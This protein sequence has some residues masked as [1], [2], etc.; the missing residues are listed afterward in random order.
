MSLLHSGLQGLSRLEYFFEQKAKESESQMIPFAVLG[1]LI[2]FLFNFTLG[3]QNG[4]HFLPLIHPEVVVLC[5][6]LLL[7]NYWPSR[8]KPLLSWYWFLCIFYL[9]P[10]L[11][12]QLFLQN[13]DSVV[14]MLAELTMALLL[15]LLLDWITYLDLL[16][17]GLFS[18]FVLFGAIEEN[19]FSSSLIHKQF[20]LVFSISILVAVFLLR[21]RNV[22]QRDRIATMN[23][24][25]A[26]M[27]HEL[28][29]PLLSMRA[30]VL[31]MKK[32]LPLL[33]RGYKEAQRKSDSLEPI[34]EDRLEALQK[35]G[36]EMVVS[37]NYSAMVIDALVAGFNDT[38]LVVEFSSLDL[39]QAIMSAIEQYSFSP[40]EINLVELLEFPN[41]KIVG[42]EAI[43]VHIFHNLFKYALFKIKEAKSGD[44]K[45]WAEKKGAKACIY[46][47]CSSGHLSAHAIGHI[48]NI[49]VSEEEKLTRIGTCLYLCKAAVDRMDGV[50]ECQSK[51][52]SY[53]F[54]LN[55][56]L[57]DNV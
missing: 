3:Y 26:V 21:A 41:L 35:A 14:W 48:F 28:R 34:R 10:F 49:G 42:N 43:F 45:I 46:F 27:A 51:G 24:V 9:M 5:A 50:I 11:M 33:V 13:Q 29:T 30:S 2:Y 57:V 17:L 40:E 8:L 15:A 38:S 23:L 54:V 1:L 55:F 7:K 53:V 12:T 36:D 32:Y 18:S 39:S 19:S 22:A 37:L 16:G 56:R 4:F 47:E 6:L 25:S 44:I 52:E 31:A 20:L